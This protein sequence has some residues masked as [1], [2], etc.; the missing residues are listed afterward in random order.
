MPLFFGVAGHGRK[1]PRPPSDLT[2]QSQQ[3]VQEVRDLR[4][5]AS[6]VE[7]VRDRAEQVPE[8]V[9][10][11]GQGRDVEHDPVEVDGQPEQVEIERPQL[12]VKDSARGRPRWWRPPGLTGGSSEAIS[13]SAT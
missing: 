3:L 8:Q 6:A 9:P 12:E 7:E 1:P 2:Q 5:Q 4:Q 11:A 13:S 10:G